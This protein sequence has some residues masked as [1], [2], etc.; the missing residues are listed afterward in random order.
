MLCTLICPCK[1]IRVRNGVMVRCKISRELKNQDQDGSG[2]KTGFGLV[3][4]LAPRLAVDH[5][6]PVDTIEGEQNNF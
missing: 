6:N 4:R 3:H 5:P 1:K 2:G